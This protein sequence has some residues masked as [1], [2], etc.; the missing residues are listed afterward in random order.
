MAA[1]ARQ[2]KGSKRLR[3]RTQ[4]KS[5]EIAISDSGSLM[6]AS[7][8]RFRAAKALLF[9][10]LCPH[11]SRV[12]DQWSTNLQIQLIVI[13]FSWRL[14]GIVYFS[15]SLGIPIGELSLW[16][17]AYIGICT[18]FRNQHLSTMG[19]RCDFDSAHLLPLITGDDL[20]WTTT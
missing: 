14:G 17:L 15:Q 4:K 7:D 8:H 2:P 16:T 10:C 20:L 3:E 19:H 6:K 1:T 12:L 18:G 11:K 9:A 5:S 13:V